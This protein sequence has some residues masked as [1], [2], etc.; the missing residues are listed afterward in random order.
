MIVD[1]NIEESKRV[2]YVQKINSAAARM[3]ELIR[4][5]LDFS[6]IRLVKSEIEQVD[7]NAVIRQAMVEQELL[8]K[9]KGGQI[10]FD[11]LPLVRG[12]FFQL[13][14]LF[15][16]LLENAVKFTVVPPV[17]TITSEVVSESAFGARR[18]ITDYHKISVK[19]NGI[20]FP[21]KYKDQI[22]EVFKR[23]H[24]QSEFKGTGIGLAICKRVVTN[25][26]GFI[27]VSSEVGKG[28][29]FS[30]YLPL[31]LQD[32]IEPALIAQN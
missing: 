30:I 15:S 27:S 9:E 5:V 16:N 11:T 18:G 32:E 4:N 26:K 19:D 29:T 3:S 31:V 21:D 6:K 22:F 12:S 17:V 20:G 23:L 8:L 13:V 1:E 2:D 14:Q 24:S 10:V 28:S 25:H 7:L